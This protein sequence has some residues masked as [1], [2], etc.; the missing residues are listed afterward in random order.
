[1]GRAL[2]AERRGSGV[3]RVPEDVASDTQAWIPPFDTGPQTGR[4]SR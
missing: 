2:D 3:E 4:H 1:M